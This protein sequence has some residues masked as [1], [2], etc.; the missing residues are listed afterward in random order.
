MTL[1]LTKILTQ[2]AYPLSLSIL[3]SLLAG[4]VFWRARR[5]LG[6]LLLGASLLILVVFSIPVCSDYLCASLERLYPPVLTEA[7]PDA[8]AIVV[9]GGVVEDAIAP[10]LSVHLGDGVDR[11]RYAAQLYR[12]GK[13]PL[14]V[15]SGGQ[16]PWLTEGRAEAYVMA[17]L[18][19]EWGVPPTAILVE[20]DSRTTYENALFSK[21]LLEARGIHSVLLVTSALHTPR[22]L[23]TF[24]TLGIRA[25]P[26]PTDI[27]VVNRQRDTLLRWLPDAEAL[28][29]STLALK[30]YL[31]MVVY[32]LRGWIR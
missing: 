7:L 25:V 24:R 2:L 19:T 9:L 17:E 31:G 6:G 20:A 26:A 16:L 22:A 28:A 14:V 18:L 21:V 11:V 5:R 1:L 10:R 32:R 3:L 13:A 12:A 4:L 15:A 30:E 27:V 23:A 8:D 29:G